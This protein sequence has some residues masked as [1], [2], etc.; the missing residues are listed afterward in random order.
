MIWTEQAMTEHP[1]LKNKFF[2][3]DKIT[4]HIT[5]V[6]VDDDYMPT[7]VAR[8]PHVSTVP[9][10]PRQRWSDEDVANLVRLRRKGLTFKLIGQDI[11]RTRYSAMK[12]HQELVEQGLV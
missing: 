9:F 3:V 8:A 10:V 7:Y 6:D 1:D 4:G 2:R 11:G 12:K 5:K